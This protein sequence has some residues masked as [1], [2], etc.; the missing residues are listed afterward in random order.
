MKKIFFLLSLGLLCSINFLKAANSIDTAFIVDG[1]RHLLSICTPNGFNPNDTYPLVIGLHFCGSNSKDY[2]NGLKPLADS[3]KMVI[4]CPDNS[5]VQITNNNIVTTAIDS[6]MAMFNID[7]KAVYLT[8][9]SCNGEYTIRQGLQKFYPFKGIFP[10][11]PYLS[12]TAYKLDSDMPIVLALGTSDITF[13]ITM[14]LYDSL[15]SHHANV[16]LILARKIG[17]YFTFPKYG[18]IMSRSVLYINDTNAISMS[19]LPDMDLIDTAKLQ[20]KKIKVIHRLGKTMSFNTM[21]SD[22]TIVLDPTIEKVVGTDSIQISFKPTV[23]SQGKAV[24]IIEAVD[25]DGKAIEQTTFKINVT[26]SATKPID[27]TSSAVQTRQYMQEELA[28][29]NPANNF[30]TLKNIETVTSLEIFDISGKKVISFS[31]EKLA[32]NINIS[33]LSNG[34]YVLKISQ[35]GTYKT[36]RFIKI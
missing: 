29:P 31:K 8:G 26:K 9:M 28:Y 22:S 35:N 27:T 25:I 6:A 11:D 21:S 12:S 24:I 30:L 17:H 23:G 2:R 19:S 16:N 32:S 13:G 34:A 10:W 20:E 1:K 5:S 3:L 7:S 4:A 36:Q 18:A 14:N 15:K 33:Y